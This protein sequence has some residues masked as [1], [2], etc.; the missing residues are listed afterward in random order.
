MILFLEEPRSRI[1]QGLGRLECLSVSLCLHSASRVGCFS[2]PE[3]PRRFLI[4]SSLQGL[5]RGR[6]FLYLSLWLDLVMK[7]V[8]QK[9][10]VVARSLVLSR[11][12]VGLWSPPWTAMLALPPVPESSVPGD[13]ASPER[14][15]WQRRT[16]SQSG[17][18]R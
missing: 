15:F 11:L 6:P 8:P 1:P 5:E 4:I 12:G 7:Q 10:W 17:D 14:W 2:S 9:G 13:P 3:T 16:L 18:F